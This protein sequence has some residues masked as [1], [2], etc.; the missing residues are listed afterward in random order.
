MRFSAGIAALITFSLNGV[1]LPVTSIA[2]AVTHQ[3]QPMV[4]APLD[5]LEFYAGIVRQEDGRS[6][7][8]A[9]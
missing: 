2:Q 9:D 8:A 1:G 4:F 3:T 5:G 7:R 6:G